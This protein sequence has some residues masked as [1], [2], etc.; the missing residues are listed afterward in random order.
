MPFPSVT[1]IKYNK[2]CFHSVCPYLAI[3]NVATLFTTIIVICYWWFCNSKTYMED[4]NFID[5]YRPL[6][7]ASTL[8]SLKNGER[9]MLR[10]K[11]EVLSL[12]LKHCIDPC[13]VGF[14]PLL[15]FIEV[16]SIY[17]IYKFQ[18]CINIFQFLCILHHVHHPKTNYC[19]SPCTCALLPLLP[20][21][22]P[23]PL[24]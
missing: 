23:L 9:I 2:L 16:T 5:H 15:L 14:F 19:L 17:N 18:M 22:L 10:Y 11:I 8:N 24:W 3:K 1:K 21:S 7:T 20:S 12:K 13:R 4:D 6:K